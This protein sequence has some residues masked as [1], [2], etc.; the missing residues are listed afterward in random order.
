MEQKD[1][2]IYKVSKEVSEDVAQHLHGITRNL[3][4]NNPHDFTRDDI[5]HIMLIAQLVT[6]AAS[7]Y[8]AGYGEDRAKD[9][10]DSVK[11]DLLTLLKEISDKSKKQNKKKS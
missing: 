3:A 10:C 6:L 7:A 11:G 2:F 5:I 9:F 8:A 1:V 4:E